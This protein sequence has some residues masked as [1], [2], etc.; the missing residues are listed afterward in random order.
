MVE[1]KLHVIFV[2]LIVSRICYALSAWD[3]FLNSQQINRSMLSFGKLDGLGSV[4]STSQCDIS[5]Y[6]RMADS[7]LLNHIQC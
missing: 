7:K 6:L 4:S 2:A 5:V 1:S 3:D